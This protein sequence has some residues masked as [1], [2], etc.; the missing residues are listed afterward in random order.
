MSGEHTR[1]PTRTIGDF[2]TGTEAIRT[3]SS[4]SEVS[5]ELPTTPAERP[6]MHEESSD[7]TFKPSHLELPKP[8]DFG[9]NEPEAA[10]AVAV[11]SP[12]SERTTGSLMSASAMS[13]TAPSAQYE[14]G[15]R[16]LVVDD[17]PLTRKLMTRMLTRLG[18]R[19]TTAE[20]GEIALDL[21]LHPNTTRP[22]PSSEDTGSSG[23]L[24]GSFAPSGDDPRY[25]VVFLD[26]QMPVM[27]GLKAV[28]T[29]RK[30]GR[31]D[32]VVGVTGNALLT[33]QEEYLAAGVDQ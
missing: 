23:L 10:D 4:G 27:S 8:R 29:L 32:F 31:R 9:I 2:S 30:R 11:A 13:T 16:V 22:T 7:S 20:N 24:D 15:M 26:N 19:V 12:G 25:A 21:I 28:A 17:D 1:V 3:Q 6:N 14:P 18:C 33:D 5:S